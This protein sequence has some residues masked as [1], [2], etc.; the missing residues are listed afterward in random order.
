LSDKKRLEDELAAQR[1]LNSQLQLQLR[2]QK[3]ADP[4][5]GPGDDDQQISLVLISNFN[6]FVHVCLRTLV[7]AVCVIG[8][9]GRRLQ[10][11]QIGLLLVIVLHGLFCL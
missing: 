2:K 3:D 8:G 6:W 5:E 7:L 4:D 9:N 10:A 1:Q 11:K